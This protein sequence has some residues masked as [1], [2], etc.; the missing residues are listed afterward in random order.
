KPYVGSLGNLQEQMAEDRP[1]QG[2]VNLLEWQQRGR[3][4]PDSIAGVEKFREPNGSIDEEKVPYQYFPVN[5]RNIAKFRQLLSSM[6][7]GEANRA[8]TVEELRNAGLTIPA[9]RYDRFVL[10]SL[11]P[12]RSDQGIVP[13]NA[14]NR[15]DLRLR[16]YYRAT[17][18][19]NNNQLFDFNFRDRAR[20][21]ET[22]PLP[23]G[24]MRYGVIILAGP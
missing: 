11:G 16:A 14:D 2:M 5:S 3:W 19:L 4:V 24:S 23:D 21:L 17:R 9:Q 7:D 8:Y 18:D 12:Q 1:E 10:F 6:E 15:D 20:K 22:Y 13:R